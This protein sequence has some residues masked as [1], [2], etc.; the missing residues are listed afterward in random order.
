MNVRKAVLLKFHEAIFN[1]SLGRKQV[2]R[3]KLHTENLI[4]KENL[5]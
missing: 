3:K 2:L 1:A 5:K 4:F